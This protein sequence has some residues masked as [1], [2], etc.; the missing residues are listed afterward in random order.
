MGLPALMVHA[1]LTVASCTLL[2]GLA[3]DW[4]VG[5]AQAAAPTRVTIDLG[6]T[7]E[8]HDVTP[9]EFTQGH[10]QEK[11]VEATFHVSVLLTSG[12]ATD[13]E[14]LHLIVESREGRMRVVDFKPR[15]EL[16]SEVAGDVEVSATV[17][18]N[19]T[20]NASLGSVLAGQVGP[21]HVQS[22]P[23]PS[24]GTTNTNGTKETY[25]RLPGKQLV[26]ASGTVNAEH[27]VFFKWRRSNQ[28]SLEGWR[29]VSCRFV[30][31]REWRGDWVAAN[32]EVLARR[33]NYLGSKVE[34]CDQ[35]S[36]VVGLYLVGDAV[37]QQAARELAAAQCSAATA[38]DQ[39]GVQRQV[40]NKPVTN[41][42]G[43]GLPAWIKLSPIFKLCNHAAGP[44]AGEAAAVP[45]AQLA[46]PS[47]SMAMTSLKQLSGK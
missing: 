31:P 6:T 16:E 23:G 42:N 13:L 17:N 30:V 29:E 39:P 22:S 41:A 19:S 32:C 25:K 14:E 44:T 11:I 35:V 10:P 28:N 8:C 2:L 1:G 43:S 24:F 40:C 33:Q 15:T 4:L 20:L 38:G 21:V 18:K 34:P 45:A 47:M 5:A 9:A 36:A 37:A 12:R 3:A 26:L 7:V 46:N 27:G